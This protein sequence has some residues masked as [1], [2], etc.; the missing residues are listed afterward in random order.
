VLQPLADPER[1]PLGLTGRQLQ[2]GPRA[3]ARR[4]P[5]GLQPSDDIN[6][7]AAA[8]EKNGIDRKAHE[9]GVNGEARPDQ[10][11]SPGRKVLPP[12]QPPGAGD[13]RVCDLAAL[14]DDSASV[15]A[16]HDHLVSGRSAHLWKA[17]SSA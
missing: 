8:V 1:D 3:H 2:H 9:E 12:K 13:D 7:G 14:A 11:P 4:R 6:D 10:E 16:N 5:P 15:A 17:S